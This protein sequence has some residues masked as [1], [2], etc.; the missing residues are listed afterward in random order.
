M[1]VLLQSPS[2]P[3]IQNITGV[4]YGAE[5]HVQ[6]R[7]IWLILPLATFLASVVLLVLS[8]L[9]S[10]RREYL[11]RNKILAAIA[12]ELHGWDRDEY[13]ADGDWKR[14]SIRTLEQRSETMVARMQ[15]PQ[16]GDGGLKFKKERE[17]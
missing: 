3:Q 17:R 6:V 15:L 10:S 12:I 7:W 9:D 5:I 4:A 8:M 2:N 13:A 1:S 16:D 11:F 14:G